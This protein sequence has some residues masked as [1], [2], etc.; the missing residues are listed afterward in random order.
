MRRNGV[1]SL[2]VLLLLCLPSIAG[3]AALLFN[4]VIRRPIEAWG[5]SSSIPLAVAAMFG[6]PLV[7]L[8]LVVFAP[9]LLGRRVPFAIKLADLA[10][11]GV[12]IIATLVVS[13]RPM[14]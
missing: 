11:L 10:I 2:V 8:A 9:I 13:F 3:M 1:L 7:F 5:L 4:L 6:M 12:G 14:V